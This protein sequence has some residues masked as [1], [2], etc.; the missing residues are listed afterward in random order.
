LLFSDVLKQLRIIDLCGDNVAAAGPLS[1]I[2]GAAAVAAEREVFLR[3]QHERAADRTAKRKRF[4]L[5]HTELDDSDLTNDARHKIIVMGL[6]NLTT[7]E[8]ARHE[9]FVVAKIVDK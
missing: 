6:S 7:I 9:L 8:S 2:D 4:F 5:R 3:P 1:Q